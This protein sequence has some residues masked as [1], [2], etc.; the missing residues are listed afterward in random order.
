M[1]LLNMWNKYINIFSIYW[2]K[3]ICIFLHLLIHSQSAC[4]L[5]MRYIERELNIQFSQNGWL[6]ISK[7]AW[8][9]M[10]L[11]TSLI[12][13]MILSETQVNYFSF[14][15]VG[16]DVQVRVYNWNHRFYKFNK[17][18][19]EYSLGRWTRKPVNH[20]S[21]VA[22]VTPTDRPKSVRN[23]CLIELFL[24]RCLCC[25]FAL[26]TFLLVKGLLS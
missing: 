25:H 8:L 18:G 11:L 1:C 7:C 12:H 22:V 3:Y 24:W 5:C 20:T 2:N 9:F 19:N 21:W 23:R 10:N 17:T 14:R 15:N 13:A 4:L 26:L 6:I 16:W